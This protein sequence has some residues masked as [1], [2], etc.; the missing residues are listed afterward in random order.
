MSTRILPYT[1]PSSFTRLDATI[2]AADAYANVRDMQIA[3]RNHNIL[4]AQRIRQPIFAQTFGQADYD[5]ATVGKDALEFDSLVNPTRA[6]GD[7]LMLMPIYVPPWTKYLTLTIEAAVRDSTEG[8]FELY[9][10]VDSYQGIREIDPAVVITVNNNSKTEFTVQVPV[11]EFV[12]QTG[13]G[14]FMLYGVGQIFVAATK[15]A[16]AI[17]DAG[18][19]FI[20][21][22]FGASYEGYAMIFSDTEIEP[23]IITYM[24]DLGATQRAYTNPPFNKIPIPNTTTVAVFRVNSLKLY[25]ACLYAT[26]ITDFSGTDGTL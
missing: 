25:N 23:R 11:P 19:T 21:S 20:T 22:A 16:A 26:A 4:L 10:H 3:R 1:I 17:T 24:R 7:L 2:T 13:A 9:P 8:N 14:V 18:A 15:V 12:A 5:T 6:G